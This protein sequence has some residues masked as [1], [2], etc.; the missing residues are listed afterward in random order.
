MSGVSGEWCGETEVVRGGDRTGQVECVWEGEG[1]EERGL[2]V[3]WGEATQ[4]VTW[5]Q[6]PGFRIPFPARDSA[7]VVWGE[8]GWRRRGERVESR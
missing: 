3:R 2:K 7:P 8:W 5:D 1:E 4:V 6:M